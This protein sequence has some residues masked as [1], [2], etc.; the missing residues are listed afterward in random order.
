MISADAAG[1]HLHTTMVRNEQTPEKIR[2]SIDILLVLVLTTVYSREDYRNC[3]TVVQYVS[4]LRTYGTVYCTLPVRSSVFFHVSAGR[5]VL[6]QFIDHNG[7]NKTYHTAQQKQKT[8][9]KVIPIVKVDTK[10]IKS[11]KSLQ[12]K[13]TKNDQKEAT[14]TRCKRD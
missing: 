9:A 4:S 5:S 3:I 8:I 2:K 14:A 6:Y 11:I 12:K 1:L 7:K 13:K 10:V